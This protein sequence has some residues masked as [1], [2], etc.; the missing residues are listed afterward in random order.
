MFFLPGVEGYLSHEGVMICFRGKRWGK[1][2][3]RVGKG[4][5]LRLLQLKV[6][7]IPKC[8]ILG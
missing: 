2:W 4:H 6:F 1:V 3:G 8:H 7:S 5:F